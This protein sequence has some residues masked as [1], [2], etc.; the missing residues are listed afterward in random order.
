MSIPKLTAEQEQAL[1]EGNGVVQGESY[2]L[3]RPE[4]FLT[5]LGYDSLEELRHELQP[6][7]DQADRGELEE[8]DV[9]ACLK[10]LHETHGT[11]AE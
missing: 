7:F 9:D 6:A 10:R 1:D 2:V 11:H 3:M 5:W 4:A 8:W